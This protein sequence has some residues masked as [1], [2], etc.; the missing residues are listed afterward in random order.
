MLDHVVNVSVYL[1]L[2]AQE[3]V[4]APGPCPDGCGA[5]WRRHSRFTRQW[6]DYDCVAFTLVIVRVRCQG[7]G[8]VWSLFPAFVWYRFRFSYRLVQATCQR[9]VSGVG[10]AAVV[11]DLRERLSPLVEDRAR[12][13][14]PAESTVRSWVRWLGQQCLEGCVRWTISFIAVRSAEVAREASAALEIRPGLPAA[15]RCRERAGRVLR[16][17][18]ALDAVTRGR[19]NISRRSPYQIRDWARVLFRERCKVLARPP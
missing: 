1:E 9:V 4:T 18:A 17:C 11:E 19:S 15:R 2:V 12:C 16:L 8:G 3:K 5:D 13:R 14:V 7:C 6:V 10:C